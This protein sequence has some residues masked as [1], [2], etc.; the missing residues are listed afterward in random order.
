MD[1]L[2]NKEISKIKFIYSAIEDGW[3]VNKKDKF[4]IFKKKHENKKK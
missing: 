3:C 4:Y 1:E 2:N